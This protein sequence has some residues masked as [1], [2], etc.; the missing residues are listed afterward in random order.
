MF[1]VLRGLCNSGYSIITVL[2]G[3]SPFTPSHSVR[4]SRACINPTTVERNTVNISTL[5]GKGFDKDLHFRGP[6]W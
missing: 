3:L 6:A 5:R 4:S 1:Q 2:D